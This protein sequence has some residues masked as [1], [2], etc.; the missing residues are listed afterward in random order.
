[1]HTFNLQK[2]AQKHYQQQFAD[3]YFLRL[4][5]L[6]KAIIANAKAAWDGMDAVVG[7]PRLCIYARGTIVC[8]ER[9]C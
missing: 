2:G 4:A 1:M 5:Q 3:M 6:K 8:S 7:M 9:T